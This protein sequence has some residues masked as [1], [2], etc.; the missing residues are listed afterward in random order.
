[1]VAILDAIKDAIKDVVLEAQLALR[2][3]EGGRTS[4]RRQGQGLHVLMV[5]DLV[6]D[7]LFGAG[8]PRAYAIT[9]SLVDAGHHVDFYP[10][11]ASRA[12]L[13][14]MNKAFAGS[15]CFHLGERGR[16]LRRLLRRDGDRFD[17]LFVSRTTP[18]QALLQARWRPTGGVTRVI[19]DAEAV[20]TPREARRR[21][22]FGTAWSEADYRAALAAELGL[23]ADVQAVTA[24]AQGDAEVIAS[25]IDVPVFVLPHPVSVHPARSGFVE[26]QDLLFVGRL[27]GERSESPNVDSILWFAAEVM[28]E[29]D[30]LIGTQYRLHIVGRVEAPAITALVS[31]RI[32]LHGVV[33]D[34]HPIY[35]RCRLFVA[36]TR[37]A[38]GIPL[39]VVEAMG[40][41]IPCVVTPLLAE[42]LAARDGALAIGD[43][44][45]DFASQC[46]RLYRDAE[47]W[48]AVRD[49]GA[50]HVRR[51]CS[52]A[53]FDLAL[54]DVLA[55][56]M[57]SS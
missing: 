22:L 30:R 50:A 20:L 10:M 18:M 44:A 6:P 42:Q 53:A 32:V 15:V 25:A 11:Q 40:E 3:I 43:G 35:D 49:A 23:A 27:T 54:G 51:F 33:E 21:V 14:R 2:L 5:D 4:R 47:T 48:L 26:R 13:A 1:M 36:P 38:A 57:E 39:K 52:P 41:G 19:Y 8:Y 16:G 7:P 24:V 29:L 9:R 17:L 12:D 45:G 34:L 28:P 46:A 37:Y 56:I 55:H 31:N